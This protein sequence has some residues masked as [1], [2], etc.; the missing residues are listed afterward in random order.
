[1][2]LSF[3]KGDLITVTQKEEGGWWEGT[4][5][6]TQKT[7]WFPSNYVKIYSTEVIAASP[8]PFETNNGNAEGD[9][10]NFNAASV[11]EEVFDTEMQDKQLV[12][13][14]QLISELVENEKEFV[15]ELRSLLAKFLDPLRKNGEV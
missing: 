14:Q 4:S 9:G 3:K 10:N 6:E 7:G 2:Q 8:F 15:S 5:H 11:S 1:M 13:R 12:Y